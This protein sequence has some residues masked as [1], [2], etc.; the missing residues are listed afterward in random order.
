MLEDNEGLLEEIVEVIGLP[1]LELRFAKSTLLLEGICQTDAE[2]ERADKIANAYADK[3]LNLITVLDP[4]IPPPPPT[5][6]AS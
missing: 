5:I 4:E 3:V 1:E 2:Y 6:D